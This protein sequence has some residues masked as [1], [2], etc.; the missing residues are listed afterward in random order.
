MKKALILLIAL[1]IG[2]FCGAYAQDNAE[3]TSRWLTEMRE[4]KH[5]FLARELNLNRDQ[6]QKF[7][8]VY[9]K[10]EDEI[11]KLNSDIRT[12]QRRISQAED[13]TVSDLEYD[14]AIQAI[15][16]AKAKEAEIEAR[17]LPE[18]KE[19]LTKK[20]LFDLKN[21]EQRFNMNMMRRHHELRES[22]NERRQSSQ[23]Q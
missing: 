7:F 18:L 15:Y 13:G 8:A 4:Y 22:R 10:M 2:G 12:M 1:L 5:S 16:E 19:V 23:R 6:Q 21:A 20:Q 9:D 17:Y 14:M 11:N 3:S